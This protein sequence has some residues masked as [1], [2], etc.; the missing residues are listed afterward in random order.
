MEQLEPKILLSAAPVDAPVEAFG[1]SPLAS[2]DSSALE[3]VRFADVIE[4][5]MSSEFFEDEKED[6][7]LFCSGED[8]DWGDESEGIV[9]AEDQRLTGSGEADLDLVVDGVFAPGNSPGLVEVANFE[10]NGVLEIELGEDFD[11]GDESEGIVIAEDQRLTGSGEADLDLVVDGV[12]APGNSPGLVEV[13]NFENNGVLEIELAGTDL[14]DFDRVIASGEAQL[15]GTLKISLID[16]FEPQIGDE[17]QF[18]TF[19]SREGDFDE[20]EGLKLSETLALVPFAT[21]TGYVLKAVGIGGQAI[22]DLAH[23]AQLLIDAGSE[24]MNDI[25]ED[26]ITARQDLTLFSISDFFGSITLGSTQLSGQFAVAVDGDQVIFTINDGTLFADANADNETFQGNEAGLRVIGVDGVFAFNPETQGFVLSAS[27]DLNVY[28]S[29]IELGG[30]VSVS[31]NTTGQ[32][33]VNEVYTAGSSSFTVTAANGAAFLSGDNVSLETE[34]ADLVFD[35]SIALSTTAQ[36]GLNISINEGSLVFSDSPRTNVAI[37][38]V[39]GSFDISENGDFAVTL[40]GTLNVDLVGFD[41]SNASVDVSYESVDGDRQFQVNTT[42]LVAIAVQ[43]NAGEAKVSF[44]AGALSAGGVEFIFAF[45]ELSLITDEASLVDASGVLLGNV[46]G[47]AGKFYGTAIVQ[48]GS[49]FA[50]GARLQIRFNTTDQEISRSFPLGD[51]EILIN[52]SGAE[53]SQNFFEITAISAFFEIG[54]RIQ[55]RGPVSFTS[56]TLAIG[57]V[58]YDVEVIADD[59]VEFFLAVDSLTPGVWGL[60]LDASGIS[61]SNATVVIIRFNDTGSYTVVVSGDFTAQ[62]LGSV[63]LSGSGRLELNQSGLVIDTVLERDG[64]PADGTRLFFPSGSSDIEVNFGALDLVID[65]QTISGSASIT[66]ISDSLNVQFNRVQANFTVG[67]GNLGLRDGTGDITFGND[68]VYGGVTGS[69]V[70][71]GFADFSFAGSLTA[72]FNSGAEDKNYTRGGKFIPLPSGPFVR[73]SGYGLTITTQGESITGDFAFENG[74]IDQNS[75]VVSAGAGDVGEEEVL[76]G[77]ANN[78]RLSTAGLAVGEMSLSGIVIVSEGFLATQLSGSF[79]YT[80]N[81]VRIE[82]DLDLDVNTQVTDVIVISHLN[83]ETLTISAGPRFELR[84][85]DFSIDLRAAALKGSFTLSTSLVDGLPLLNFDFQGLTI[86]FGGLPDASL[87]QL[88]MP[89][90]N[91]AISNSGLFG[92]LSG[93]SVTGGSLDLSGLLDLQFNTLPFDFRGIPTG[94][95]ALSG[96]NLHL[97]LGSLAFTGQIDFSL[98]K[99]ELVDFF[100]GIELSDPPAFEGLEIGFANVD[101]A[102]PGGVGEVSGVTGG[103]VL[104]SSGFA[105]QLSGSVDINTRD[106]D[107]SGSSTLKINTFGKSI[108]STLEIGGDTVTLDVPK[109]PFFSIDFEDTALSLLGASLTG[110]LS[111]ILSAGLTSDGIGELL[112]AVSDLNIQAGLGTANYELTNLSGFLFVDDLGVSASFTGGMAL[113]GIPDANFAINGADVEF[114]TRGQAL[115]KIFENRQYAF[116]AENYFEMQTTGV[117]VTLDG[118]SVSGDFLFRFDPANGLDTPEMDGGVSNAQV[119]IGPNGEATLD[120]G[121]GVFIL[122][123]A[124]LALGFSG[125]LSISLPDISASGFFAAEINTTSDP[126]NRSITLGGEEIILDLDAGPGLIGIVGEE[127]SLIVDDQLLSGDFIFKSRDNG[128]LLIAADNVTTI[129]RDGVTDYLRIEDGMGAVVATADGSAFDISGEL[130]VL[131]PHLSATGTFRVLVNSMPTAVNET[132]TVGAVTRSIQIR[133]GPVANVIGV[134][135]Q[136]IVGEQSL[137]GTFSFETLDNG[138]LSIEVISASLSLTNN[139]SSLVNITGANGNLIADPNGTDGI[140]TVG[141]SAFNVPGVIVTFSTVRVELNTRA[142]SVERSANL[143][144]QDISLSLPA[145]P[146]VRVSAPSASLEFSG[147]TVGGS[148]AQLSG[149]FFFEKSGDDITLAASSV[150]AS[151]DVNGDGGELTNGEGAFVLRRDGLAGGLKGSLSLAISDVAAGADI[152]LRINTTGGAVSETITLGADELEISFSATEGNIFSAVL[153]DVSIVLGDLIYIEGSFVFTSSGDREVVGATGVEIFIG[154]GPRLLEDGSDNPL[155]R[156]FLLS[157]ATFGV[158]KFTDGSV[159]TYALQAE[160]AVSVIG[161]DNLSLSGTVTLRFNSFQEAIRES[162]ST[163]DA[164]AP[165]EMAADETA[166]LTG[167][168]FF[169][170]AGMDLALRVAGQAIAANV[171][172]SRYRSGDRQIFRASLGEGLA[173]FSA[174][175]TSL[176]TLEELSGDVF[177]FD[178]GIAAQASGEL[179][180]GIDSVLASG[181]YNLQINTTGNTISESFTAGNVTREVSIPAGPYLRISG[182]GAELSVNGQSLTGNFLFEQN[183]EGDVVASA[184]EVHASFGDGALTLVDAEGVISINTAGFAANISG[185]V[186]INMPDVSI[187]AELD[188]KI[189]TRATAVNEMVVLNGIEKALQIRAGPTFALEATQVSV[190]IAGQIITADLFIEQTN[191]G[192]TNLSFSNASLNINASG[193]TLASV[194]DANGDFE[195]S[196]AGLAGRL[197]INELLLDLPGI[198]FS[199]GSAEIQVNTRATEADIVGNTLPAGPFLRI[200]LLSSTAEFGNLDVGGVPARLVGDFFFEQANGITRVAAANVSAAIE[201]NGKGANLENGRGALIVTSTGIAGVIEGDLAANLPGISAGATLVLQFNNSG[202]PVD[203]TIALGPDSIQIKYNAGQGQFISVALANFSITVADIITVEGSLTFTSSNGREIAAGSGLSVFV[204]EG[205]ATLDDGST[206]PLA[207]GF[208]LNNATVGLIKLGDTYAVVATGQVQVIGIS[209]LTLSGLFTVRVN[210]FDEAVSQTLPVTGTSETVVIDF[211][212]LE[213]VSGTGEVFYEI[214]G[215]DLVIK[216]FDQQVMADLALRRISLLRDGVSENAFYFGL[217]DLSAVFSDGTTD[218]VSLIGASGDLLV[219][220]DGIAAKFDGELDINVPEVIATGSYSLLLN[221]TGTAIN[222][223]FTVGGNSRTLTVEAGPFVRIVGSGVSLTIADQVLFGSFGFEQNAE[224]EVLVQLNNIRAAFSDAGTDI[225]VFGNGEGVLLLTAAGAAADLAGDLT[226]EL[227][228]VSASGSFRFILNTTPDAVN[229]TINLTGVE[230]TLKVGPGNFIQIIGRGVS[231][232]VLGNEISGNIGFEKS[233]DGRVLGQLS[234]ARLAFNNGTRDILILENG[235]GALVAKT[236]GLAFEF[237]GDLTVDIPEV[238]AVGRFS[239][240]ANTTDQ[241]VDEVI[242]LTGTPQTLNLRAGKFIQVIGN[243]VDVEIAGQ[244]LRGD[245]VFERTDGG[246]TVILASKVDLSLGDDLVTLSGGEGALIIFDDGLAGEISGDVALNVPGLSTTATFGVQINTTLRVIDKTII[247]INEVAVTVKKVPQGR[248]FRVEANEV[249]IDIAGQTLKGNFIFEQR[250]DGNIHFSASNVSLNIGDGVVTVGGGAGGFEINRDG[251]VGGLSIQDFDFTVPGVELGTGEVRVEVNTRPQEVTGEFN[252][253]GGPEML[254]LPGGPYVRVAL[255]DT[256]LTLVGLTVGG[257]AASLSGDFFFDQAGGVTRLAMSKVSA[258]VEVDGSGAMLTNGGGALVILPSGVAGV[259]QG[260]VDVA[261]PGIDAGATIFIRINNTGTTV[262]EIVRLGAREITVLFGVDEENLFQVTLDGLSLNIADVIT[263]EGSFSFVSRGDLQVAAGQNVTIFIGAGPAFL[264]DGNLNSEARGILIDQATVGIVKENTAGGTLY[265]VSA[266]GRVRVVGLPE[267]TLEGTVTVRINQLDE[268]VD[269]TI[270][271]PGETENVDV[272]F[273]A[274]E[275]ASAA[276]PFVKI[277]AVGVLIEV[278]DQSISGDLAI[279]RY[280]DANDDDI[281]RLS[282]SNGR[283]AFGSATEEILVLDNAE[284]DIL[285]LTDGVGLSVTGSLRFEVPSISTSADFRLEVNTTGTAINESYT[286]FAQP[287]SLTLPAGP[288]LFIAGDNVS[289]NI[290]DQILTGDFSFEQRSDGSVRVTASQ[291]DLTL[292]AD[293]TDIVVVDNAAGDFEITADGIA[294]ALAISSIVVTIPNVSFT[295]GETYLQLNTRSVAVTRE[296]NLGAGLETVEFPVGPFVRVAV[297]DVTLSLTDLSSSGSPAAISGSFFFDQVGSITRVAAT[298]VTAS[299]DVNGSSGSLIDGEGALVITDTGIAASISGTLAASVPS[300]EAGGTLI[301][302]FNNTG[303]AVD[304]EIEIGSDRIKVFFSNSDA[305][306]GVAL[307]GATINIGDIVTIKGNISFVNSGDRQVVAGTELELFIGEGPARLENGEINPFARGLLINNATL[308]LVKVEGAGGPLYALEANGDVQV[309]GIADLVLSGTMR[310]SVNTF[311]EAVTETI[312]IPGTEQSV[313]VNFDATQTAG[314]SGPYAL[315]EAIGITLEV[316]GQSLVAD[317]SVS[318]FRSDRNNTPGNSSDDIEVLRFGLRNVSASFG[319]LTENFVTLSE[320]SGDFLILPEGLAAEIEGTLTFTV[321]DVLATGDFALRINTTGLIINESYE[322]FG[323]LE[324]LALPAGPYFQIAGTGVELTIAGQELGGDFTFEQNADG[325]VRVDVENAFLD[326]KSGNEVIVSVT[327]GFGTFLIDETGIAGGISVGTFSLDVEGVT[328]TTDKVTV[329]INTRAV[330]VTN[331]FKLGAE[332]AQTLTLPAGPYVRVE[333]LNASLTIDELPGATLSGNFAFDQFGGVTRLALS[334][335]T[336]EVTVNGQGARLIDGAGALVISD[337]G[338]A[339]TV[340]GSLDVAL[341]GLDAGGDLFLRMNNTGGAIDQFLTLGTDTFQI[342]FTASEGMVFS[343]ALANASINIADIILIQGSFNFSNRG[344]YQIAGGTDLLIFIGEGIPQ[345]EDGSFNPNARGLLVTGATVG[346]IKVDTPAGPLYAVEASGTI[347]VLGIADLDL[348]GEVSIRLNAITG[349]ILPNI[350]DSISIPGLDLPLNIDF[351]GVDVPNVG[352][353]VFFNIT[354]T[355]ISFD[356]ADLSINADLSFSRPNIDLGGGFSE[357]ALGISLTN[358]STSIGGGLLTL[359][360]GFGDILILSSGIAANISGTV[361]VNVPGLSLGSGFALEINTSGI[362]LNVD[363]DVQ[364]SLREINVR[365]GP[366]IQI[367]GTV[368]SIDIADQ[369]LKGNFDFTLLAD[370]SIFASFSDVSFS[371]GL[372]DKPFVTISGGVGEFEVTSAGIVGALS[373]AS[374]D[375][376]IPNVFLSTDQVRIE[377]NTRLNAVTRE[378]SLGDGIETLTLTAG[379]FVRVAVLGAKLTLDGLGANAVLAGDFFFESSPTLTRV[380]MANVTVLVDVNGQGASLINGQGALILL[381]TGVAGTLSGDLSVT[382]G[383]LD[384]GGTLILSI[385]NSG[386]V[387]DEAITLGASTLNVFFGEGEGMTFSIALANASLVIGDIIL[388]EGSFSFTDRGNGVSVVAGANLRLFIGEGPA[389]LADGSIN[390]F[391]KG[392]L[393]ENATLGL[394]KV[395]EGT[396]TQYAIDASGDVSVVGLPDITLE[397][398]VRVRVN[399]SN[400]AVDENISIPGTTQTVNVTF[401]ADQVANAAGEAF[402]SIQGLGITIGIGDNVITSDISVQQS[403]RDINGTPFDTSDDRRETRLM[404]ANAS[405]KISNAGTDYVTMTNGFG[406]LLITDVGLVGA[407]G[408]SFAVNIPGVELSG[409]LNILL[410]TTGEAFSEEFVVAADGTTRD[411]IEAGNFFQLSGTDL[412]IEIVGQN[413]S[414][415]IFLGN[416]TLADG[417]TIT[418]L[419][420]SNISAS[421]GDGTT[422]FLDLSNG[423][424][425]LLVIPEG[426]A[427]RFTVSVAT[428]P[429]L[430]FS[431][432]VDE[433]QVAV[434]TTNA[435]VLETIELAGETRTLD[436]PAGPYFRV[437]AIGTEIVIADQRLTADVSFQQTTVNGAT[438]TRVVITRA[439]LQLGPAND[440]FL[441]LSNG[442]GVLLLKSFTDAIGAAASGLAGTITG[443]VDLNVPGVSFSGTLGLEINQT[444]DAI[445]E[446]FE[447]GGETIAVS[448]PAGRFFKVSAKDAELIVAGQTLSGDFAFTQTA[449]VTSIEITNA[450]FNLGDGLLN[451]TI[452]TGRIDLFAD[453]VSASFLAGVIFGIDDVNLSVTELMLDINTR[454]SVGRQFIRVSADDVV[455]SVPGLDIRGDIAFEQVTVGARS[456]VRVAIDELSVQIGDFV[457]VQDASAQLLIL[458]EGVAGQIIVTENPFNIPGLEFT[459]DQVTVQVNTLPFAVTPELTAFAG[460]AGFSLP[461]GPFVRVEALN[462]SIA[463]TGLQVGDDDVS[464]SGSFFFEQTGEGF[465]TVTTLAATNVSASIEFNGEGATFIDGE[466]AFVITNGGFAGFLTGRADISLGPIDAGGDLALRINNTG[467]AVDKTIKIGGRDIPIVFAAN[468]DMAFDVS[469]SDLTLNIGDFV[470]ISGNV[471][472]SDGF[473]S[474]DGVDSVDIAVR[475]FAGEDLEIF[476]GQGPLR[477]GD[478]TFNPLAK[479]ALLTDSRIGLIQIPGATESD[480]STYALVATGTV[481]LIGVDGVIIS[482]EASIRV[483]TTG[484]AVS[485]VLTIAGSTGLGVTVS[486]DDGAEV[487]QFE[488]INATL[489]ILGQSIIG[490]F[491]FSQASTQGPDGT[492]GTVDDGTTLTIAATMVSISLGSETAGVAIVNAAGVLIV[493]EAGIAGTISGEVN[494]NIPGIIFQGIDTSDATFE[495]SINT[496]PTAVDES[497]MVGVSQVDLNL[498]AGQFFRVEAEARLIV[499]GQSIEG[500]FAIE[501]TTDAATGASLLTIRATEVEFALTSG[502]ED[503]GSLENVVALTNGSGALVISDAGLAGE[504]N[505]SIE[506]NLGPDVEV[507]GDFSLRINNT[508]AAVSQEFVI[509]G[510]TYTLELPFGPYV[511][512]EATNVEV[513]LFDQ[514][515]T[516]DVTLEQVQSLGVDGVPGGTGEDFDEQIVRVGFN[517]VSINLADG[518]LTLDNGSGLFVVSDAGLAGGISGDVALGVEGVSLE[519][520]LTLEVNNTGAEVDE[521]LRVGSA[522]LNLQIAAGQNFR[523][524]GDDL[525]LV[526]GDLRLKGDFEITE[527]TTQSGAKVLHVAA[528]DLNFGMGGTEGQPIIGMTVDSAE[529]LFLPDGV[530]ALVTG[531]VP[532]LNVDGVTLEGTVDFELNTTTTNKRGVAANTVRLNVTAATISVSG[533]TVTGDFSFEQVSNPVANTSIIRVTVTEAEIL[534]GQGPA[535]LENE[536]DDQDERVVNPSAQGFLLTNGS[537]LFLL[538]S[539]GFAAEISAT[540]EILPVDTL[541]IEGKLTLQINTTGNAISETFQV[542]AATRTLE[543]PSGPYFRVT[544]NDIILAVAGQR[545]SGNFVFESIVLDRGADVDD[546]SDDTTAIRIAITNAELGLGDKDREFIHLTNGEGYF[547]LINKPNDEPGSGVAG[548]LTVDVETDLPDF[549]FSGTLTLELNQTGRAIDQEFVVDNI[550][551]DLELDKERAEKYYEVHNQELVVENYFRVGGTN[552]TLEIGGQ[553]LNGNFTFE[554]GDEAGEQVTILSFDDVSLGLG[555]GT[556]D[557]VN[558]TLASGELVLRSMGVT[559]SFTGLVALNVPDV[560]MSGTATVT[561]DT[562][563]NEFRVEVRP[564]EVGKVLINVLSQGIEADLIVIEEFTLAGGEQVAR[565]LITNFR[566]ALNDGTDD[567]IVVTAASTALIVNAQ[568]MGIRVSNAWIVADLGDDLGLTVTEASFLLNTTGSEIDLGDGLDGVP[569]GPYVRVEIVSGSLNVGDIAI[570]GGFL[571]DQSTDESGAITTRIVIDQ[572]ELTVDGEEIAAADGA[573]VLLADGIAGNLTGSLEASG[574]GASIG[575]AVTVS[576]N[577]TGRQINETI[578]L[579]ER[580]FVI[581]LAPITENGGISINI[582]AIVRIGDFIFLEFAGNQFSGTGT[583]FVGQGPAF[584]ENELD[585][586]DE[587]VVNPSAQG[588]LLTNASFT[589]AADDS[590]FVAEGT[591]SVIGL[592]GFAL[593]GTVRVVY[594]STAVTAGMGRTL[595]LPGG[596]I[597]TIPD[598]PATIVTVDNFDLEIA[599]Q[600]INGD[601]RFTIAEDFIEVGVENLFVGLGSTTRNQNNNLI[602]DTFITLTSPASTFR[603]TSAGFSGVLEGTLNIVKLIPNVD[604]GAGITAKLEINTT[605]TSQTLNVGG[606]NVILPSGPFLRVTATIPEAVIFGSSL[607]GT[608]SFE[609]SVGQLT[610][611]AQDRGVVPPKFIKIGVT[612]LN[613]FLGDRADAGEDD[614]DAGLAI[615]NGTGAFVIKSGSFVT[616]EN[617]VTTQLPGSFSGQASGTVALFI[618]GADVG[619]S[620]NF[621]LRVNTG[622]EEVQEVVQV[623]GQTINLNIEAGPYLQVA[624]TGLELN[625]M[626]TT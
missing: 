552:L 415:N 217:S 531:I 141:S 571:F 245:F 61:I 26:A 507:K 118:N 423:S 42:N 214:T 142:T 409:D 435:A 189:S 10:N 133:A 175:E 238:S 366:F 546:A 392:L 562:A 223:A 328:F 443:T 23:D 540:V 495:V 225:M 584:L 194:T 81:D 192:L 404:L 446:I 159:E 79:R 595:T 280:K 549:E 523:V 144:G 362:D 131:L 462:A 208:L 150:T 16:G 493:T 376:D 567:I 458:P 550:T 618:P 319:S 106:L 105:G 50:G 445:N 367:S 152:F 47:V 305:V 311:N 270:V 191:T 112:I 39:D 452:A 89:T 109:G 274:A 491:A 200:A 115:T 49:A 46:N 521:T 154:E 602:T 209:N 486:F 281:V 244:T 375:V 444:P 295:V 180:F 88:S 513:N 346:L 258:A 504:I 514:T 59:G 304:E 474:G 499:E 614:D 505:G 13:A 107:F 412:S 56:E 132:V 547:L 90:G 545:L 299:V 140:L 501:S 464:L 594:A 151:V 411:G 222:Q 516:G 215:D 407:I 167:D 291:V 160:G 184:S 41:I 303:A 607:S 38:E 138:G 477:I 424:G 78:V 408:G 288:F 519:G 489:D 528:T 481:E 177:I 296:I 181:V 179:S 422:S 485:E 17:F 156:G 129:I 588:F 432:N 497:F 369:T 526:V 123:D 221:T 127:V 457:N 401:A 479:G 71:S 153:S 579:G 334:N 351:S 620:G 327:G 518:L 591:V 27:G 95:F 29:D 558:V 195:L 260:K 393:I 522:T 98:I 25:I 344:D 145:G 130:S 617:N 315:I 11:W 543:L 128:N 336:A 483:N 371:L 568:G 510:Q 551:Q 4:A 387:V 339:G 185:E 247:T 309:I 555:D 266:T 233:P 182:I 569:A 147:L 414:G 66:T 96:S 349:D 619:F 166:S 283:A 5:E 600:V 430:A 134:N 341:D 161:I 60:D 605:P 582:S 28:G 110:D 494:V 402:I 364:G 529:F 169:E 573:V 385:N 68:A 461:V 577:T 316:S 116:R 32:D 213:T 259:V 343:V 310:V 372:P 289:L 220:S 102:L 502:G 321:P 383:G 199:I 554:Q 237:G 313:T 267:I 524:A 587:R 342:N 395:T 426:V 162:V 439:S 254:T 239:V 320:G 350:S 263:V 253:G 126:V 417:S 431:L 596:D 347:L 236:G 297:L 399:S 114:S 482:A 436:L 73:L 470:T 287:R 170:I 53:A 216:A 122:T 273:S 137:E 121:S 255:L 572:A 589:R 466:G 87:L 476:L 361:G 235:N 57:G 174:A 449:D 576:I 64:N 135:A 226:I 454:T 243:G 612:N 578:M 356:L 565:L 242:D 332:G 210:Q 139:G 538:T 441:T 382:A 425:I 606:S 67:T 176:L 626:R 508:N 330:S 7:E 329:Q 593:S 463:P 338:L 307:L 204:G 227:D 429:S 193:Q 475:T 556:T 272:V 257:S 413:L 15:G 590:T 228:D 418:R 563:A 77:F 437:A 450:E 99:S 20:I 353:G 290:A 84:A 178:D 544:G 434:N 396:A 325:S 333:I 183:A 585:D 520:G 448:L 230:Q 352:G 207:R 24:A 173:S 317:L 557:F 403:L 390:P 384:A 219:M 34:V 314:I 232:N 406:D 381:T 80:E 511:R 197:T 533:Q 206:N 471:A 286:V 45:D 580:T 298:N 240:E 492:F 603:Y 378:F 277:D 196:Q 72:E 6:Q 468:E 348:S 517:N 300:L 460:N 456:V 503:V 124:G 377:I 83:G 478:E 54:N 388:L 9:I 616:D 282:L 447:L 91:F 97:N 93:L 187:A 373:V 308:G 30:T 622:E 74:T 480:P 284:G 94:H 530:A 212:A 256:S 271:F 249:E 19:A 368:V 355:N 231:L 389:T 621:S 62:N 542:G 570:T 566:L 302:R 442:S 484:R 559:G 101:L 592:D 171:N 581:D 337:N 360:A 8:F 564:P 218:L 143:E 48:A 610:Q 586:Q 386:V 625:L 535:F 397:G 623:G 111:L 611:E 70:S 136:L 539:Y 459:V 488:A 21:D 149:N 440:P 335:V 251:I 3:E 509:A 541:R 55:Y 312:G 1:S 250:P 467:G 229:R 119:S 146:F 279:S 472:F 86:D 598:T 363:F 318:R 469:I 400:Q 22:V 613:I 234:N 12:F 537:G 202:G 278:S 85:V 354:A 224:R 188:L 201:V 615:T 532:I 63:S 427:G 322:A 410:N 211:N 553:T 36:A 374:I 165:V 419:G 58:D 599:G 453:G 609:Q 190:D 44:I 490:N 560:T 496:T 104:R 331:E 261:L 269:Q 285:L 512:F 37:T 534:L 358:V 113:T 76:L 597:V 561:F 108:F 186:A 575:A 324:T 326:L 2:V 293:G 198:F 164:V 433:L 398:T 601:F 276:S 103:L 262:D 148:I 515:L 420:L 527:T 391:A 241:E 35:F 451:I 268:A 294:G 157:N 548:K 421:F 275:V 43:S 340:Q 158:V 428:N 40:A 525:T 120:N 583:I 498:P 438:E 473:I 100:D 574:G 624:A 163:G 82:G 500:R 608:F 69:I 125:E 306:F 465:D 455:F 301:L 51:G 248:F 394:I 252:F 168:A 506:I 172:I 203:E 380:A 604:F 18:L 323:A 65:N 345:L 359:D 536:L 264:A 33:L 14:V 365:A 405:L 370:G 416:E 117:D 52:F 155:A 92:D 246:T 487:K 265:A 31:W 379:P 75:G 357:I 292:T 205:P